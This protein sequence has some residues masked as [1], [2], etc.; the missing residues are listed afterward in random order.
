MGK[1][2]LVT[3]AYGQIGSE[4]SMKLREIYGNQNVIVSDVVKAPEKLKESGPTRYLD[5]TD[6]KEVNKM[7]VDENIDIIYHLAAILSANAEKNPQMAFYINMTGLYNILEAARTK[8]VKQVITPSSIAA[9]GP[10]TPRD[11]TPDETF[12]RP[13]SMYGVT[14]VSGELLHEYYT[15]K[16]G[17]DVRSLRYPGVVSSE[18]EPGGGT[19]DYAVDI[20]VKAVNGEKYTCF[21]KEDTILPFMYMPDTIN[22]I[23]SLAD[24]PVDKLSRRTYNVVAFSC[25]AKDL[26]NA[27]KKEIP[28][29]KC[30]Y[31]PDYRQ[32]IADSWPRTIDDSNARKDWGWNHT[33]DLSKM[34]SDMIEKLRKKSGRN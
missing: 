6:A 11:N 12:L 5:V 34:T 19:T 32:D 3:G 28:D 33:Y 9:F 8:G 27:I 21:V 29:F 20:Y 2:V 4:L 13:T 17:L 24:A 25:S 1:R 22:S 15:H 7:V 30:E 18:T 10:T 14:K 26:E 23:L 16:Y 31:K